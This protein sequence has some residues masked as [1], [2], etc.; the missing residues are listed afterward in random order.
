MSLDTRWE[1]VDELLRRTERTKDEKSAK[2]VA[3][4]AAARFKFPSP[5]LPS[6]RAHV[7]VPAVTMGVQVG[8]E[9][10]APDIVVVERLK[11]GDTRLVMT[12]IVCNIEQVNDGEAHRLW[13]R[14]ASIPGQ[15][16]YL[17]VPVG[18]GA[19]AKAIC[20][21]AKIRPEGVRT[22][23][24]TPRGFEINDVTEAPSPLAALMP[25]IVRKL[26]ATP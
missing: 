17:Y 11:T 6:Y 23:R 8:D 4:I 24:W 21:R 14:A 7:N 3:E 5:E 25:P 10:I 18:K 26:L 15:A 12:A 22:Y 19:E 9:E 20:R 1:N 13:A 2:A 16:F